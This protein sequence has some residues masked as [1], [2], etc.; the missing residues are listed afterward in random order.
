MQ[1]VKDD[2]PPQLSYVK[3]TLAVVL[4]NGIVLAGLF[5]MFLLYLN[6]LSPFVD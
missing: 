2:H 1:K 6:T 4:G 5:L 3:M